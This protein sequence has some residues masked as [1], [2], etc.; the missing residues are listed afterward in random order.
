MLLARNRIIPP[1]I[2]QRFRKSLSPDPNIHMVRILRKH[3]LIVIALAGKN[4][5]HVFVCDHPV[6]L[7]VLGDEK[8]AVA[9]LHPEANR[10]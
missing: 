7:A 6:V 3:E 4:F 5:R 9:D 8:V 10:L 1:N 2:L